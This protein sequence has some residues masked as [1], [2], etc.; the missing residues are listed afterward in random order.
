MTKKELKQPDEIITYL[1]KIT[2][3]ITEHQNKIAILALVVIALISGAYGYKAYRARAES[4]AHSELWRILSQVPENNID[5]TEGEKNSLILVKSKLEE[6]SKNT[7]SESVSRYAKYYLADIDY[8]LGYYHN[9]VEIFGELLRDETLT[10]EMI[11][12]C[13]IGLGYSYENLGNY[14]NAITHF[15]KAEKIAKDSYNRV[16]AL[17][18]V[19]RCY[20]LAGDTGSAIK[21]YSDIIEK[22]P[23]YPDIEFI[24]IRLSSIS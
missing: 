16:S 17:Y 8:R 5:L 9:A 15:S 12:V 10:R 3:F 20:E 19:A 21:V 13:S 7:G 24:K 14:E 1:G 22:N 4:R 23:D 2:T 18:G 11:Y 6:F